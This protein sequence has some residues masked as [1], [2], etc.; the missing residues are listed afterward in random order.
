MV[1]YVTIYNIDHKHWLT[2]S[3]G[4]DKLGELYYNFSISKKHTQMVN[5][6][7]ILDC[8]SHSLAL[9]DFFLSSGPNFYSAEVFFPL[10]NSDHVVSVSI[11][12]PSNSKEVAP[13][14]FTVVDHSFVDQEGLPD[15]L[16]DVPWEDV[17]THASAGATEI[18]EWVEVGSEIYIYIYIHTYIYI[19][20]YTHLILNIRSSVILLYVC[21]LLVQLPWVID[22]T[23]FV[24][25]NRMYL[26]C[27]T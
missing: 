12:F 9:L 2:N 17:F 15:H 21:Q 16:I 27:L 22:I 10:G 11:D 19:Y 24:H 5:S 13:F 4:T 14:H 26:L 20:I 18:C 23:F 6:P 25:T 7:R 3:G 8:D 1:M